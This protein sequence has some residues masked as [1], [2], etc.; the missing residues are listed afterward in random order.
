MQTYYNLYYNNKAFY[1]KIIPI[2]FFKKNIK[3]FKLSRFLRNILHF[4]FNR[5]VYAVSH[6]SSSTNNV[7]NHVWSFVLSRLVYS[8]FFAFF[9]FLDVL[10][11]AVSV[12]GLSAFSAFLSIDFLPAFCCSEKSS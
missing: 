5:N 11:G 10:L 4:A 9:S 3:S 2:L 6:R 12:T 8:D 7:V 1:I